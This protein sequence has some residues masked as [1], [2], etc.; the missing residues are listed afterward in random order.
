[1]VFGNEYKKKKVMCY[2][3]KIVIMI[4]IIIYFQLEN[5]VVIGRLVKLNKD[6]L[7]WKLIENE[8]VI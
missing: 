3:G 2:W 1:M 6:R 7:I 5:V 8:Y 4:G